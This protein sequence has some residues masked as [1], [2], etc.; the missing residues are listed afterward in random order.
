MKLFVFICSIF[1]MPFELSAN[2]VDIIPKNIDF[3]S[4]QWI[5]KKGTFRVIRFNSEYDPCFILQNY[6]EGLSGELTSTNRVC[7]VNLPSN[8]TINVS[9]DQSGG[10]WFE[11]FEWIN[12]GLS[13]IL[14]SPNGKFN[15][16]IDLY[17]PENS[18]VQCAAI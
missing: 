1:L 11:K 7:M 10:T 8:V 17:K 18:L 3:V 9:H 15:C 6:K 2:E 5:D 16:K 12:N 13:F 14:D 4:T